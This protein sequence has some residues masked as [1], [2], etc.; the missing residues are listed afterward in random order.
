MCSYDRAGWLS[1]EDL[2]F[3]NQN[4]GK[5]AENFCHMNT[6]A[7]LPGWILQMNSASFWFACGIF[8]IISIK[9]NSSDTATRVAKAM[10]GVKV[11]TMC[12]A[13][14]A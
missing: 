3:S 1:S 6:S 9:F 12:F 10:K 5:R 14:F 2:G 13:M 4:L 7:R 11:I 8:H